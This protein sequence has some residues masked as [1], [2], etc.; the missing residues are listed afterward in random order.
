MGCTWICSLNLTRVFP[1]DVPV[2]GQNADRSLSH[3]VF[4]VPPVEMN[5]VWHDWNQLI[6]RYS[7]LEIP[8]FFFNRHDTIRQIMN[9]HYAPWVR[10][11]SH[12]YTN[13]LMSLNCRCLE[14]IPWSP[15]STGRFLFHEDISCR[16]RTS[17]Y[18]KILGIPETEARA[19][20][21]WLRAHGQKKKKPFPSGMSN[22]RHY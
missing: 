16:T 5:M 21:H 11:S 18:K 2:G 20:R 8:V 15:E 6:S 1:L 9:H 10:M 4:P 12:I 13:I 17:W 14:P 7:L 22:L 3:I 19:S